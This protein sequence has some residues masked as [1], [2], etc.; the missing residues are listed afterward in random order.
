[1]FIAVMNLGIVWGEEIKEGEPLPQIE[2]L[3]QILEQKKE[4]ERELKRLSEMILIPAGEFTM[5]SNTGERNERPAHQVYLDAYFIDKYEVTQLQFLEMMETNPSYFNKCSLCPVEKV[6]Y[7]EARQY[8][9]KHNKRLPTEAEWEK[10]ARGGTTGP[11]H[12]PD[13]KTPDAFAW[14]GNNA[15]R[16]T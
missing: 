4:I 1:I 3:Q 12:W 14:Q 11:Y 5:G 2:K 10:A 16:Q 9:Q 15:S 13:G 7:Y 6:T 8:C